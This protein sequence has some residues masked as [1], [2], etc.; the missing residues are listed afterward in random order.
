M[1]HHRCRILS[2]SNC[3]HEGATPRFLFAG[4]KKG[5]ATVKGTIP[6]SMKLATTLKS[7]VHSVNLFLPGH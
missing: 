3:E 5:V 2:L 6:Q 7:V 4:T 1:A